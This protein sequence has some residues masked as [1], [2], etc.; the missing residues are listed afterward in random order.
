MGAVERFWSHVDR[1]GD[2]WEW[3]AYRDRD[4]YGITNAAAFGTPRAH[5][6]AYALL[7]G[8]IP[9]GM[10]LDHLCRN[11]SCVNPDH[12]EPV[13]N[14]ENQ[15]RGV[16][17]SSAN[18]VKTHCPRGHALEGDNLIPYRLERGMRECRTC[19]TEAARRYRAARKVVAA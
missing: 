8:P 5:R 14:R 6:V 12:L 10:Q 2:C 9:D 11:R 15:R 17:V 4:G 19:A 3:T 7:I 16:T 13:T 18:S 1:T